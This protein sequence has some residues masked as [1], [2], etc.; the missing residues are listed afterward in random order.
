MAGANGGARKSGPTKPKG[1]QRVAGP[2]KDLSGATQAE[3][4]GAVKDEANSLV[5][6]RSKDHRFGGNKVFISA[7]YDRLGGKMSLE[8]SKSRLVDAH[9]AGLLSLNRA[10]L[11]EAMPAGAVNR[12][13][14][15][16]F[17][18]RVEYHF[19]RTA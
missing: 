15:N 6:S 8:T 12:S 4:A 11:V 3:F 17:N 9:R 13:Q 14:I 5:R 19:V 7:L 16:L 1:V 10:D 2:R 18:G